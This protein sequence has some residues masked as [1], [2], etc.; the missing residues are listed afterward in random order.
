[1]P[2][3]LVWNL[4]EKKFSKTIF[5]NVEHFFVG[6]GIEFEF[7]IKKG[8]GMRRRRKGSNIVDSRERNNFP[9]YRWREVERSK[10]SRVTKDN[11]GVGPSNNIILIGGSYKHMTPPTYV[12]YPVT[13]PCVYVRI[14]ATFHRGAPPL[15]IQFETNNRICA[16]RLL[17]RG[18]DTKNRAWNRLYWIRSLPPQ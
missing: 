10:R 7:R 9:E 12:S 11:R 3:P 15:S 8:K 4:E 2:S 6:L 18:S 1:M 16:A 14:Y 13:T 17:L 5:Q